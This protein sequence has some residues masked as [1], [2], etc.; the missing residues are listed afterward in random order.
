MD[1]FRKQG[2]VLSVGHLHNVQSIVQYHKPKL[3][4]VRLASM[5]IL[6]SFNKRVKADF[7]CGE[8]L[9]PPVLLDGLKWYLATLSIVANRK[10]PQ[11]TLE[12]IPRQTPG[13]TRPRI[14]KA[15][16]S[17]IK[18]VAHEHKYRLKHKQPATPGYI[19]I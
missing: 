6:E 12:I 19:C 13:H 10:P 15:W 1:F 3:T 5:D 2:F 14:T 16:H 9:S 17:A 4:Q 18:Y 11:H 7:T 8:L